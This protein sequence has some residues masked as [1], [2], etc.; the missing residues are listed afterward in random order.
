MSPLWLLACAAPPDLSEATDAVSVA[1][2]TTA[3]DAEDAF[4]AV[5]DQ[6]VESIDVALPNLASPYIAQ[7][8][9]DLAEQR[10]VSVRAVTD[11]DQAADPGV[12]ILQ[13]AGI[14]LRLADGEVAYF[15]FSLNLD[16][17]W[18][19]E[20]VIQ[21]HAMAVVDRRWVVSATSLGVTDGWFLVWTG[22]GEDLAQ[23]VGAELNQVI[24]GLD[25]S[26]LTAYDSLAKSVTD[27]RWSYPS[28]GQ[29]L[30]EVWFGPQERLVK[31][32]IDAVYAARSSVK[33]LTNDFSD[34]SLALA[35][36]AKAADGFLVEVVVG[37]GFG[38]SSSA[39]SR[40]LEEDTPDVV[41]WQVASLVVPT[42]VI[43]DDEQDRLGGWNQVKTMTLSHDLYSAGRL[44]R[45]SPIVTDQLIDGN[46]WA[47][48]AWGAPT[49]EQQ[50]LLDAWE[51]H[52]A[53]A[54]P[55]P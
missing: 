3:V 35:L 54:E 41:K 29:A 14:P 1:A 21:S 23:D 18:E 43:I 28:P 39:N 32:V 6:A 52:L 45:S 48:N 16:V 37:P 34:P 25:A 55:L 17:R 9:V 12:A 10:G 44:Y 36:Q 11:V 33:V 31:R 53:E 46:L 8:L 20:Q 50:P 4:V 40:V 2:Y 30:P 15:E 27:L 22:R 5:L 7:V 13:D 42:V 51:A 26:S 47:F 49:G 38:S 24:G 19:S